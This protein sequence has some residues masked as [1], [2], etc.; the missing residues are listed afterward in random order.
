MGL[1]IH[2]CS[3]IRR[4]LTQ[5]SLQPVHLTTGAA[6]VGTRLLLS[7]GKDLR[8]KA[9]SGEVLPPFLQCDWS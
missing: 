8:S 1:L 5:A 4:S 3:P 9:R 7:D 6:G 2:G